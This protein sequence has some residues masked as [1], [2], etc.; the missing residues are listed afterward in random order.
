MR[1]FSR[2]ISYVSEELLPALHQEEIHGIKKTDVTTLYETKLLGLV[3]IR[4][5]RVK[6]GM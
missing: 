3:Q 2:V 1:L 4:Q 6:N 5:L